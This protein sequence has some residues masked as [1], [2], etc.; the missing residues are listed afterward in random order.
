MTNVTLERWSRDHRYGGGSLT[1]WT[2]IYADPKT[3]PHR[4]ATRDTEAEARA[5]A[6][7]HGWTVGDRAAA[8]Q[9]A[10]QGG[11]TGE[12]SGG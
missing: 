2:L 8:R 11:G 9:L 7:R 12:G 10:A 5:F 4:I 1:A 3:G 6:N